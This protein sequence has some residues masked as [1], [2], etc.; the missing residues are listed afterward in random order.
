MNHDD[1]AVWT[2]KTPIMRFT[3]VEMHQSDRVK[4]QFSMLQQIRESPTC[5]GNWHKKRVDAQWDYS[6]W[7]DF[8]KEMCRQWRNRRQH[9]LNEPDIHGVR[10]T[11]QY[12]AWFRSVTTQ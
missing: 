6:D 8:A 2:T 5:L 9:F 10:P 11:Q 7:R 3:M 1:A 4:L 12:M